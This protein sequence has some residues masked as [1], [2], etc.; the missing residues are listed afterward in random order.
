MHNNSNTSGRLYLI[1]AMLGDTAPAEVLPPEIRNRASQLKHFIVEELRTARRFLKKLDQ[2]T[3]IDSLQF[4][5]LNE[6]TDP[7]EIPGMLS[8]LLEG[9]DMGLLSEAGLP[10]LADPGSALVSAAHAH[11]IRVIPLTG[12][13]SVILALIASGFNGQNFAFHGYLPV[14]QKKRLQAIRN[15]EQQVYRNDQTQIFIETPY[16][17]LKMFESLLQAC[18]PESMLCIAA[19]ITT[20]G[21]MIRSQPVEKWKK[22]TPDIHK[23]PAVFLLYK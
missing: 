16:R 13:S 19:D 23:K 2:S 18:R 22:E 11:G 20:S 7:S 9:N 1:P 21:E 12:P 4:F 10:C 17:N 5:V 8:P 6:H 3:E 15:L 14:D